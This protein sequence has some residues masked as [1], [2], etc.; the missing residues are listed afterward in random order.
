MEKRV[1]ISKGLR[2]KGTNVE[3]GT[4]AEDLTLEGEIA[5]DASDNE[6]K[7]RLNS[8]TRTVVTEDQTQTLSNKTYTDPVLNGDVSGTAIDTDDTLAANS[9]TKIPSQQ[10]V[11]A[12]VDNAT[13]GQ[14]EAS[15]IT[16]DNANSGLTAT[17]VQDA[18]DEVEG[19]LDTN[20]A[21]ATANSA[22]I[23]AHL[24]D[25]VDAHDAS[26]I[27]N[28]PS[29]NLAATD[30]QS[31]LNE[32][33][34]DIDGRAT[35]SE[36]T[37][38]IND[39]TDAHDASAISY[40]NATSGLTATEVQSAVDEVE[41]RL[42]T[43][44]S[45]AS[46]NA[47]GL[48][49]HIADTSTHGV[50]GDILGT[51]DAQVITNKD[52]DG[53]TASNTSRITIPKNTKANLDALTR[54][55]ATL[56]FAS[57]ESKA[58]ID[59]GTTLVPV[60]SGAGGDLD[61]F[62]TEQFET[63]SA[64][65]FTSG[66]NATY[67]N[68]GTL[69]GTLADE[70]VSPIAGDQSLKY[71]MGSTSTN[72]W[73]KSPAI[74]LDSKQQS[75]TVGLTFYYTYDGADDDIKVVAYD[76]TN[77]EVLTTSVDFLKAS[78][79]PQRFSVEFPINSDTANLHWGFQVVTG[80]S[81][82]VLKVD[83]VEISTN[84]F[85]YKNLNTVEVYRADTHA[86]FGSTNTRIP[87]YTNERQ[88][89]IVGLGSIG[90]DS[91]NGW[92]FTA[93]KRCKITI[94]ASADSDNANGTSSLGFSLNSSQLTTNI[95]SITVS[96]RLIVDTEEEPSTGA[97][98]TM[99]VSWS[100]VLEVGDVIRVHTDSTV[101]VN[102]ALSH[103]TLVA[104]AET[105]H[106]VAYNSR[107]AENSM[108][109]L[110]TGNGHGSTNTKI[111]RFSTTVTNTGNA[112]T[113]ADSATD[114]ASFTI[115]EDGVYFIS[116]VDQNISG[117]ATLGI[118]L[119]STELTTSIATITNAD[120]LDESTTA[121][122][123]FVANSSW[124]G[125]LVKG[126]VVRPHTDGNT[127]GTSRVRF[128]ISKI[129]V[130]DLLGVPTP[131]TCYIKDVKS[132]G[133]NGG[134]FTSGAWQTRDLNTLEGDTEFVTLDS[135]TGRFTLQ[136][137]KYEIEASASA[138]AVNKHNIKLRN[139]TDSTDDIIGSTSFA[140]STAGPGNTSS[141]LKSTVE[142]TSTKTFEI[143]HYG[144]TT[145]VTDGFGPASVGGVDSVFT[146]VEITKVR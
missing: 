83:D 136:S 97:Y 50:S 81:G 69:D 62:Y 53:G 106:V 66:N 101:P 13:A 61:T 133:T 7:V 8:A 6:L 115:N 118:S 34:T 102:A 137:G 135:G 141:K 3:A 64:S 67:D 10:A 98:G 60:G 24:A 21:L 111:R 122:T 75:Q 121:E 116:Y 37:D 35:S 142:I 55:E 125:V 52:I 120:K 38:H 129:G 132:S 77:S 42:D 27:S 58:Y 109:R 31:A 16:Y 45:L 73:I 104:E 123:N 127:S 144:E 92:S 4:G 18:V 138:V 88:N 78:S 28:V 134:T 113:Y 103:V 124:A 93:S 89:T 44:E 105:E 146:Q 59:D 94:S 85:V 143:Q 17:N 2:I 23:S 30:V 99:A 108:V 76:N 32:L 56:V 90:N 72:D 11:K 40:D 19:R 33:Q 100:G 43:V 70:T 128:T 49:T 36:I 84:P 14:D 130:G 39:P 110:H 87:Y 80:N 82:A 5:V 96:D 139:I 54:K 114:G 20:E 126:D 9:D 145:R 26:A 140:S 15:E 63:T 117:A 79:T 48:S 119:N 131:R 46:T 71:T 1:K 95:E 47:T 22:A 51:T 12:Y 65:D 74:A 107:N 57:D 86:G 29:G 25:T 41:G 68:G 91:T 112:I